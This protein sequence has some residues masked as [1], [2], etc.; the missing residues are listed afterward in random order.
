[1]GKHPPQAP[2]ALGA[3]SWPQSWRRAPTS[4]SSGLSALLGPGR[5]KEQN[6][7]SWAPGAGDWTHLDSDLNPTEPWTPGLVTDLSHRLICP[8]LTR[9]HAHS[10]AV[11]CMHHVSHKSPSHS[12]KSLSPSHTVT[13]HMHSHIPTATLTGTLTLLHT[14]LQSCHPILL[15][16]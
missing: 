10:H 8:V 13:L 6:P 11:T 1:M 2:K 16:T 14:Q 15:Q 3:A 4:Y 9:P 12:H 7:L 5:E